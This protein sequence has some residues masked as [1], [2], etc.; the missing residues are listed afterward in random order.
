MHVVITGGAAFIGSHFVGRLLQR[1]HS[2]SAI[3]SFDAFYDRAIKRRNLSRYLDNE[4]FRLVEVDL[5]DLDAAEERV[6]L[7]ADVMVHLAARPG[8]PG[9]IL[10]PVLS[11][12]VNVWQPSERVRDRQPRR[13]SAGVPATCSAMLPRS[14]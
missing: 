11:T 4:R 10:D 9:S 7:G 5:L 8:I 1:G 6:G 13:R 3:D 14:P 12:R 2:V